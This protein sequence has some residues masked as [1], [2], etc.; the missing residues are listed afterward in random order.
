MSTIT[1]VPHNHCKRSHS[2]NL[3]STT[4]NIVKPSHWHTIPFNISSCPFPSTTLRSLS[5]GIL[6]DDVNGI[7]FLGFVRH[8]G[9]TISESE[10]KPPVGLVN[11]FLPECNSKKLWFAALL[12][13][14]F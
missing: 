1:S 3:S 8:V 10:H 14:I 9:N 13:D 7:C 12:V 6:P 4:K 11:N 5:L 2:I